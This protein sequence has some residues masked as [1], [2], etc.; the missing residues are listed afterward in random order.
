MFT[1]VRRTF[2]SMMSVLIV[3]AFVVAIIF[4][5]VR[6]AFLSNPGLNGLIVILFLSGLLHSFWE[7]ANVG[8][9]AK[10]LDVRG[11]LAA[12]S[13]FDDRMPLSLAPLLALSEFRRNLP[14]SVAD[15]AT[16]IAMVRERL[17]GMRRWSKF[18]VVL[19]CVLG[20]IGAVWGW[21]NASASLFESVNRI[22]SDSLQDWVVT[23]EL[24][25]MVLA[26]S[27]NIGTASSAM[28]FGLICAMILMLAQNHVGRAQTK[29]IAELE[30][31]VFGLG[32]GEA[33]ATGSSSGDGDFG[34]SGADGSDPDS[35]AIDKVPLWIAGVL[36]VIWLFAS[37]TYVSKV[38]LPGPS[39]ADTMSDH[40][41]LAVL[42][43]TALPILLF[44]AIAYF[45]VKAQ[46]MKRFTEALERRSRE[47]A[48][49][50]PKPEDG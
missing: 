33:S 38:I 34:F 37:L 47:A 13:V 18:C 15:R 14:A 35:R 19:M 9:A 49:P 45:V 40:A 21:S 1:R 7:L 22:N 10:W 3:A 12:L 50:M 5:A 4:P 16:V 28:L 32:P 26:L 11:D 42:A 36:S 25:S 41:I 8:R 31:M 44:L 20:V 6:S 27:A 39:S 43:M 23:E 24:R 30:R 48:K 46:Q 29:F 17:D 2:L